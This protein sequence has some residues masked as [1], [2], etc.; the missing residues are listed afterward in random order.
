MKPEP[1]T[2]TLSEGEYFSAKDILIKSE[3][4]IL[5]TL[6]YDTHVVLPHTLALTYL[7]TLSL[8]PPAPT[9]QS[10]ALAKI[11]MSHLNSALLSPQL[12]YLT[13]QPN[14]LAVAAI[15][16]A[17]REVK[18]KLAEVQWWRVWDVERE[19]L[20]FLVVSF[21]SLEGFVRKEREIWDGKIVPLT[22]KAIEAEL[23]PKE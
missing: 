15:Y 20:G 2:Y 3:S 5:R 13:H 6:A 7:Q 1:V 14:T 8:L 4:T 18:V 23:K 12:L 10:Y 21:G 19:E 11:T 9:E 17:A 16:L 22:K